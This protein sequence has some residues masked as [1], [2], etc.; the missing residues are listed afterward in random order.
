MIASQDKCKSILLIKYQ[1]KEA[2]MANNQILKQESKAP[3]N[4]IKSKTIF[5]N[6]VLCC[7]FLMSM[8]GGIL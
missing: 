8:S 2:V 6:P 4:D 7:Q 3:T 5:K 1:Y